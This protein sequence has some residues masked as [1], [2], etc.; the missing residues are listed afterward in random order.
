MPRNTPRN[1]SLATSSGSAAPLHAQVPGDARSKGVIEPIPG[2]GPTGAGSREHVLEV[3]AEVAA[4]RPSP[5]RLHRR[6]SARSG[7]AWS[8][9]RRT[10]YV[11]HARDELDDRGRERG[12]GDRAEVR[13]LDRPARSRPGCGRPAACGDPARSSLS[14]TITMVGTLIASSRVFA[15]GVAAR[16]IAAS[17]RRSAPVESANARNAARRR[18]GDRR[19][20]VGLERRREQRPSLVGEAA[21]PAR[22]AR[23]SRRARTTARGPRRERAWST[24]ALPS[25]I[26][27]RR[28][29]R[30]RGGRARPRASRA[31]A[32]SS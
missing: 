27:R 5:A 21:R 32:S 10:G 9:R 22:P 16:W 31:I 26:R 3:S 4:R 14:P 8:A 25:S 15:I 6:L 1:T 7:R 19:H 13:A 17:A 20:V 28:R 24:R 2:F 12:I 30:R 11:G 23:R 29:A 18:I